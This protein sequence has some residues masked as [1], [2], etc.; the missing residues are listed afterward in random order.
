VESVPVQ[1]FGVHLGVRLSLHWRGAG[2][3]G[4]NGVGFR[5]KKGEVVTTEVR[6]QWDVCDLADLGLLCSMV[7]ADPPLHYLYQLTCETR[8]ISMKHAHKATPLI[9][10][11]L[12]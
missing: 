4:G 9:F 7:G 10:L 11:T 6:C 2:K 8:R 3:V 5:K 1:V 12:R